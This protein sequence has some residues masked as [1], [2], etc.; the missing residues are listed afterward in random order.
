MECTG[1]TL[2]E[3]ATGAGLSPS[4]LTRYVNQPASGRT[5]TDRTLSRIE[6]RFGLSRRRMPGGPAAGAVIWPDAVP[7]DENGGSLKAW[8]KAAVEEARKGRSGVAPWIM[9][10]HA[11]DLEGI[12][13]GDI[14]MV[15]INRRPAPGDIVCARVT[16][17]TSGAAETVF[18]LFQPP[19]VIAH[20]ARLG[21]VRPE[22]VD[23][24]R[25][26]ILGVVEGLIRPF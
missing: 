17:Y 7:A 16:D 10:G 23:E 9:R 15:D 1:L 22:Q 11:L 13:P 6:R 8:C 4:T 21:P 3:I 26:S 12:L 19:Y 18:R 2:S 20:S 5:I 24:V 14:L 25:V